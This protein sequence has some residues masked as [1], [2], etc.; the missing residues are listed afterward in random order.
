WLGWFFVYAFVQF[1]V[2][3]IRCLALKD[4]VTMY[5]SDNGYTTSSGMVVEILEGITTFAVSWL[6]YLLMT[7]PFVVDMML[8]LMLY[9]DMRFSF[10]L[11][12]TL[13][14]ERHY[15]KDAPIS[16]DEVRT[17]YS[18]VGYLVIIA[19]FI[20]LVWTWPS[21]GNLTLWNPTNCTTVEEGGI[22]D[23]ISYLGNGPSSKCTKRGVLRV[24]IVVTVPGVI[25]AFVVA[26]RSACS[27][28]VAYAAL[29]VTL[30]DMFLH[31]FEPALL[32]MK[33][34]A[35]IGNRP[36]VEKFIDGAEKHKRFGDN[37][38]YR[39]T[40]EFSTT[41]SSIRCVEKQEHRWGVHDDLSFQILGD[42]LVH[43]IKKQKEDLADITGLPERG[44]VTSM[45]IPRNVINEE[46]VFND[47][48]VRAENTLV[49]VTVAL[50]GVDYG[51]HNTQL[52]N[53]SLLRNDSETEAF[54]V[55]SNVI[56]PFCLQVVSKAIWAV[57]SSDNIKDYCY[58]HN[59]GAPDVYTRNLLIILLIRQVVG[60]SQ[61]SVAHYFGARQTTKDIACDFVG[62]YVICQFKDAERITIIMIGIYKPLDVNGLSC[63][64][65]RCH[66]TTWIELGRSGDMGTHLRSQCR[67][68][69]E[70]DRAITVGLS[71]LLF[72]VV[73]AIHET[74]SPSIHYILEKTLVEE[75][76]YMYEN[77]STV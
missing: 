25:P 71:Y 76:W 36:W 23:D 75:D 39:R 4:L 9:L 8:M 60:K 27:A 35:L 63:E 50:R 52:M 53:A 56:M 44:F 46:D 77:P 51:A 29:N 64:G 18:T 61:D 1:Y 74:L 37:T 58:F 14:R 45:V 15:L 69:I 2:S 70:A 22:N 30:N 54:V 34:A 49:D 72:S 13:V 66:Q 3:T 26:L 16:N 67:F 21:W 5:G 73:Q 17:A 33:I 7:T 28:L 31:A 59:V 19:V 55:R 48:L 43:K 41:G 47:L 42:L 12:D 68:T 10:G 65:I 62:K 11:L 57:L 38:L 40:T 24:V 20:A 6:L 32:E